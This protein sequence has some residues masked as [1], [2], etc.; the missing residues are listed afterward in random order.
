MTTTQTLAVRRD[1]ASIIDLTG[2]APVPATQ[3]ALDA[4]RATVTPVTARRAPLATDLSL[5]APSGTYATG[6]RPS[7]ASWPQLP[8]SPQSARCSCPPSAARS[9]PNGHHNRD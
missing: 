8:H 5:A 7:A 3:A 2:D 4:W 1:L 9:V 6:A